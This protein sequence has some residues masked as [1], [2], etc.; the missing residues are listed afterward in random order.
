AKELGAT[1]EVKD[2]AKADRALASREA[3]L[4]E[5]LGSL[6]FASVEPKEKFA[7]KLRK[8]ADASDDTAERRMV[9]RVIAGFSSMTRE[10]VRPLFEQKEY[11]KAAA[12][13]ELAVALKPE[14]K[15]SWFDLAR[16]RANNGDR[17]PAL[18][19]LERAVA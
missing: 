7:A 4:L 1:E 17:K 2:A 14:A 9:R 15:T 16:A 3:D 13:L 12:F 18:S 10:T 8:Q 11:E 5:Q 6:T 19:A